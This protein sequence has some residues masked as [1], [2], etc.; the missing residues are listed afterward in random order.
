MYVPGLSC[1]VASGRRAVTKQVLTAAGSW[2]GARK[3]AVHVD[4]A[5]KSG[6]EECTSIVPWPPCG[7]CYWRVCW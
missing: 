2:P 4:E 7:K 6:K 3:L 5:A 1:I